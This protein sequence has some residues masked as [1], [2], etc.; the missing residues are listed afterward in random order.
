MHF[1]QIL[2]I[3]DVLHVFHSLH[4]MHVDYF[5]LFFKYLQKAPVVFPYTNL[6]RNILENEKNHSMKHAP[7]NIMKSLDSINMSCES[8]ETGHKDWV[9][10]Q[11]GK[12]NQG[13]AVALSMAQH[14]VRKKLRNLVYCCVKQFKELLD[15]L[16]ICY[17]F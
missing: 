15:I 17:I 14:M 4:I 8:P 3:L 1:L 6:L 12:T 7:N 11:G 2:Q 13:P 16:C 10:K 5:M 9:K